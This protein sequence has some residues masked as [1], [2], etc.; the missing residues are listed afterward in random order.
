MCKD[1]HAVIGVRD[2]ITLPQYLSMELSQTKKTCTRVY[3]VVVLAMH[4]YAIHAYMHAVI[5]GSRVI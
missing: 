3:M 2:E 4:V 1:V 5:Q